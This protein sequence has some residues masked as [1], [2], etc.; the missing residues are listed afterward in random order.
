MLGPLLALGL[1]LAPGTGLSVFAHGEETLELGA[2][3]VQPGGSVEVRGDLGTGGRFGVALISK[4]DGSRWS[5]GTIAAVEEGHFDGYVTLPPDLPMGDYL[6][7]VT[8]AEAVDPAT[9]RAPIVIVGSAI[10]PGGERPD[11][12]EGLPGPSTSGFPGGDR[13]TSGVAPSRSGSHAEPVA[14]AAA[15]RPLSVVTVAAGVLGVLVLGVLGGA[16]ARRTR[17]DRQ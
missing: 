8:A 7:E 13:A 10:G 12:A 9:A 1:L 3:R 11:Q 16:I 17:A 4:E 15:P 2:E 5:L 6:V 14:P